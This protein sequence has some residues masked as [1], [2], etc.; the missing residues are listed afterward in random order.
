MTTNQ[1]PSATDLTTRTE[2]MTTR[3]EALVTNLPN[4]HIKK[5][6][7]HLHNWTR[8]V[9]GIPILY[10]DEI[11]PRCVAK[12]ALANALF[13]VYDHLA[14]YDHLDAAAKKRGLFDKPREKSEMTAAQFSAALTA[15]GIVRDGGEAL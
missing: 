12:R 3:I 14:A 7:A 10:Y 13:S 9:M 11:C 4:G 6:D 15:S 5:A 8:D 1:T 2:D